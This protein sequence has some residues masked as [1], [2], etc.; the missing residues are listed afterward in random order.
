MYLL[1]RL[2]PQHLLPPTATTDTRSI[3]KMYAQKLEDTVDSGRSVAAV[4]VWRVMDGS[5]LGK[6]RNLAD[7]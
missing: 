2:K 3:S 5:S 7:N 1:Y 6:I 4:R